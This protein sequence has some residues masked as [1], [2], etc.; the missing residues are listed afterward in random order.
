MRVAKQK[1]LPM[2]REIGSRNVLGQYIL[3]DPRVGSSNPILGT[4]KIL[5]IKVSQKA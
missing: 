5:L 1:C 2:L 3:G 4:I